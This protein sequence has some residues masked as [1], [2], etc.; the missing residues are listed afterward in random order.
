ME[1]S[2][3]PSRNEPFLVRATVVEHEF[4]RPDRRRHAERNRARR[5]GGG[6]IR[7]ERNGTGLQ[8]WGECFRR[9]VPSSRSSPRILA[10][11]APSLRTETPE[12]RNL[13]PVSVP[14]PAL[15]ADRGRRQREARG[16][17]LGAARKNSPYAAPPAARDEHDRSHDHPSYSAAMLANV[18]GGI[19]LVG[20]GIPA[21]YAKRA[22][23]GA[24]ASLAG[25]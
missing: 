1:A 12:M 9:A 2:A 15:Q 18:D 4:R 6:Q 14:A 11:P 3:P 24:P 5:G 25:V 7:R 21:R 22:R 8:G 17:V 13:S 10:P 16:D 23:A 20:G 19:R